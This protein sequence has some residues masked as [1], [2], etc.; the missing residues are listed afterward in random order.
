[1]S[2]ECLSSP[3]TRQ[4]STRP[5]PLGPLALA[6]AICQSHTAWL[7]SPSVVSTE[8]QRLAHVYEHGSQPLTDLNS[9]A[10]W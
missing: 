7:P 3:D 2:T 5:P 4:A 8:G 1:M 10:K 6:R 9:V